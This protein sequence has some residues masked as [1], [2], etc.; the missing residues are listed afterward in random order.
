MGRPEGV[1][2]EQILP[3]L[4]DAQVTERRRSSASM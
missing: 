1:A 2:A 3:E 4:R